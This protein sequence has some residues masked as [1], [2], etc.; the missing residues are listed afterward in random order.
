[1]VDSLALRLNYALA[2][3]RQLHVNSVHAAY[4]HRRIY[5]VCNRES[6]ND[7]PTLSFE[8]GEGEAFHFFRLIQ[9][10]FL[11]LRLKKMYATERVETIHPLFLFNCRLEWEKGEAFHF[12]RCIQANLLYR[13]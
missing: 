6:R 2:R 9:A 3:K 12:F 13:G 4:A 1:M 8:V 10:N 11:L 5:D 7:S